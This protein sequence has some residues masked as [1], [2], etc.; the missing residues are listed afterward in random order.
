MF[1][2]ASLA[3]FYA[4]SAQIAYAINMH[5][6]PHQTPRSDLLWVFVPLFLAVLLLLECVFLFVFRRFTR[7]A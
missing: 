3:A 1:V 2:L 5:Y 4:L 7:A 6:F